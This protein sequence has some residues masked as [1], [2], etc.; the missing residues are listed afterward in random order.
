MTVQQKERA[1]ENYKKLL[2]QFFVFGFS[3]LLSFSRNVSTNSSIALAMGHCGDCPKRHFTIRV[4]TSPQPG[5][6]HYNLPVN[7]YLQ[8]HKGSNRIDTLYTQPIELPVAAMALC[9]GMRG[10]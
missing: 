7:Q 1:Q 3:I 8:F 4:A 9:T 6:N 5:Y 2:H 10:R